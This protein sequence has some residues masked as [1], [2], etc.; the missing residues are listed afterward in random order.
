MDN[1]TR[2]ML[3]GATEECGK[4]AQYCL[5]AIKF[6][7]FSHHPNKIKTNGDEILIN[8]YRLQSIVEAL[9]RD[10]VLPTYSAD[11]IDFI[12]RE[13]LK[14]INKNN[15]GANNNEGKLRRITRK[16]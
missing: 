5:K 2:S 16:R 6:G 1:K 4:I 8:Y 7:L 3:I 12:K 9:Q 11:Y 13:S 10:H 15:W 14:K